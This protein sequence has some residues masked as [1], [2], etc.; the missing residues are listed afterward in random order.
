[1]II[2]VLVA[3]IGSTTT[4]VNAFTNIK[5]NNPR[6]LGQGYAQ[7]T[8]SEGDVTIGLN[9]AIEDLKQKLN[10]T[11]LTWQ[12]SFA[13]SSA[14]GGLKMTVHGLVYDMTVKAAKE[15]ALGAGAN[16]HLISA[17]KLNL[18][19]LQQIKKISPNII[20]IA[21]GVDYGEK[22]TALYNSQVLAELQLNI[23]IIYAGN[24]ANRQEVIDIFRKNQQEEYLSITSNVYPRIDE[25][26]VEPVR[27]VIQNLFEKH[28]INAPGMHKV[29]ETINHHIMPTPGAVMMASKLLYDHLGNIVTFDVGGATTDIHSVCEVNE[30]TSKITFEPEP[31]AKRTVEGDLGVFINKDNIINLY[32]KEVLAKRINVSLLELEDMLNNYQAIPNPKQMPLTEVLSSIALDY[33]LKRHAGHLTN[34]FGPSGKTTIVEGKDLSDVKYIIAT[35]GALCR[36]DNR[37]TIISNIIDKYEPKVLKPSNKATI[38]FDNN[39]IMASLGVLSM[40]YPQAALYLL[41]NSLSLR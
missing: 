17:G 18:N 36:L 27:Q 29:K 37:K 34:L 33:A 26:V 4:A 1:M 41:K 35:G 15:A 22:D 28:I 25:L 7:T 3:E 13:S 21:G 38:L 24:I 20:L 10:A 30:S 2:D 11:S 23:P 9:Q 14:A 6:F 40:S 5:T 31:L 19:D 39:Y 12:E 32:G 16:I 8:I